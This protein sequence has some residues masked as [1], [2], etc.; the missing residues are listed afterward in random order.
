M[1]RP[2]YALIVLLEALAGSLLLVK[3]VQSQSPSAGAAGLGRPI[4]IFAWPWDE[5]AVED[6]FSE[7]AGIDDPLECKGFAVAGIGTRIGAGVKVPWC[8]APTDAERVAQCAELAT[9]GTGYDAAYDFTM[10]DGQFRE[11]MVEAGEAEGLVDAPASMVEPAQPVD[12]QALYH[13]LRQTARHMT[14]VAQEA[15]TGAWLPYAALAAPTAS[16]Q[17]AMLRQQEFARETQVALRVAA[18]RLV[19]L[20]GNAWLGLTGPMSSCWMASYTRDP[21]DELFEAALYVHV[22][23]PEQV[24]LQEELVLNQAANVLER[25]SLQLQAAALQLRQLA[26]ACRT[27][28]GGSPHVARRGES[29]R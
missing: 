8:V 26:V 27:T 24:T 3:T 15:W 5:T 2:F 11:V 21:V 9:L 19:E 6:L 12:S 4:V 22:E 1:Y 17:L 23:V 14:A 13:S 18:D 28:D 16:E 10:F 29:E 20:S 7:C 25:L